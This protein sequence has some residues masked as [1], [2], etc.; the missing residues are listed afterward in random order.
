VQR[1]PSYRVARPQRRLPFLLA[2][3]PGKREGQQSERVTA[4]RSAGD[5]TPWTSIGRDPLALLTLSLA[6]YVKPRSI[7][8]VKSLPWPSGLQLN[9]TPVSVHHSRVKRPRVWYV[10]SDILRTLLVFLLSRR[11]PLGQR[12]VLVPPSRVRCVV[13]D[14]LGLFLHQQ[15]TSNKDW[16]LSLLL[17]NVF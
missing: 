5:T 11:A 15:N 13:S 8:R 7:L 4:N 3:V 12:Q 1:E 16:S 10:L 6:R 9:Y 14:E 2:N 17:N